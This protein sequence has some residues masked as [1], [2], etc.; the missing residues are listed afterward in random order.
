MIKG[1]F[2]M[3]TISSRIHKYEQQHQITIAICTT[4]N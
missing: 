1:K 3:V 4:A 2:V